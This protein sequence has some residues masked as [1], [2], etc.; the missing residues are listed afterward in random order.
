[1]RTRTTVARLKRGLAAVLHVLTAR[2]FVAILIALL[3]AVCLIGVLIPQADTMRHVT[4]SAERPVFAR[5]MAQWGLDRIF[6]SWLFFALLALTGF[7]TV[8]SLIKRL[9]AL[10]ED[11]AGLLRALMARHRLVGS[12]VFHAG[13][14]ALLITGLLSAITRSE[15]SIVLT[16]GQIIE[17]DDDVVGNSQPPRLKLTKLDPFQVR[18]EQFH[19]IHE[20]RWGS[21]DYTS[22]LTVIEAEQPVRRARVRIN[23]PLV[24][25]GVSF[26]QDRHGFSPSLEL[27]DLGGR[28]QFRSWVALN[29]EIDADPVRYRDDF[30]VPGT[31][32][33]LEAEFFPDAYM[34]AN[35]L[36]NRSPE[37]RNCAMAVT[38]REGVDTVYE[39]AVYLGQVVDIGGGLRLGFSDVR[40]W[41]EFDVVRDQGV[42]PLFISAWI[43]VLGLLLRY[44]PTITRRRPALAG[45]C[46]T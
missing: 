2:W 16:E 5:V 3:V 19:P 12:L 7:S 15:G 10:R 11:D 33:T 37:P 32:L 30:N 41:S 17:I 22:E 34:E 26:Y 14:V 40:Y 23:G 13:L 29:S 9:A 36:H 18:F 24:Y 4:W 35:Q 42:A 31:N 45:S 6:A 21:P 43:A 25:R 28:S 46:E 38:V 39:G 27:T 44:T 20:G 1:M 8:V